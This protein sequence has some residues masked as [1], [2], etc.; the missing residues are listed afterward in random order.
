MQKT[1]EFKDYNELM[2][3][4]GPEDK[5][6]KKMK[7]EFHV[8]IWVRGHTV[9]I[10][11]KANKVKIVESKFQEMI[12]Q[13][14]LYMTT[15]PHDSVHTV[16]VDEPSEFPPVFTTY[17]YKNIVPRSANQDEYVKAIREYDLVLSIGPAGTGKTFL[18]VAVGLALLAEHKVDRLVLTRPVIEAGESLGFLPGDFTEKIGPYIKPLEDS[19]ISLIGLEK[20]RYFR[21]SGVIE[22]VPLA[23]MRGRTL[24]NAFI[25]LDEAQNSSVKQMMM[26]L[27]RLGAN[28]QA[29]ITGDTTQIDL[30]SSAMSGL[31]DTE[32]VLKNINDIKFVYFNEKDVVRHELVKKIIAAYTNKLKKTKK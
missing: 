25:I 32:A 16:E 8:K 15:K 1:I 6:L 27:T 17:R 22:I 29:V 13:G 5:Y 11:G 28:S 24:N 9:V 7:E 2:R 4:L 14:E 3:V 20:Y 10:E 31:I 23:Y 12:K 21:D 30:G 26:F 18:A 19:F